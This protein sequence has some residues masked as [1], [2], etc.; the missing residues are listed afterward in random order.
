MHTP[1]E[2][3]RESAFFGGFEDVDLEALALHAVRLSFRK[4]DRIIE[5][6]LSA[7]RFYI[8]ISGTLEL[9]FLAP[10]EPGEMDPHVED[11][12][13]SVVIHAINE[14]GAM[15]GWSAM[16]EPHRYRATVS[17]LEATRLLV[18][19]RKCV[20]DYPDSLATASEFS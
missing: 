12:P 1:V 9:S 5:E 3:L 19:E 10:A 16:V 2:L 14:P 17:A 13:D 8:L 11:S 7:D 6:G 15:I 18:F 20:K 4:G